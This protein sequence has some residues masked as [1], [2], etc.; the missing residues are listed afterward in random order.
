MVARNVLVEGAVGLEPFGAKLAL[1]RLDLEVLVFN[2]VIRL[3]R[4]NFADPAKCPDRA[5]LFRFLENDQVFDSSPSLFSTHMFVS[6]YKTK[7]A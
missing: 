1:V 6:H 3:G 5:S 7:A 4:R 2:V